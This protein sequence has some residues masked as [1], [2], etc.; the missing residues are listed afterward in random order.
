MRSRAAR[1]SLSATAW[2]ALGV[3]AYFL[4][5]TEQKISG[6]GA[7]LRTFDLHAREVTFAL[8]DARAGQQAY[9]AAGQ[10]STYWMPKVTTLVQEVANMVD[11]LRGSAV[12]G[13]AR[14]ALLEASASIAD[15]GNIDKRV[16]DY[17]GA[18]ES[19]MASDVVFSE[20]GDAAARASLQ[21]ETARIEEHQAFDADEA[22]LR[23]LQAYAIG[24]AVG[25]SA[26]ILAIFG[27]ARAPRAEMAEATGLTPDPAISVDPAISAETTSSE[28][29][30]DGD[31]M[32]L[33][34]PAASQDARPGPI[35]QIA[36]EP[37]TASSLAL[38]AAAELCTEFGRLH[39]LADLKMLL[40]RAARL[41]DASGLVVW[42]GNTSGADLQPVMA[43]GYSD[44]V[45]ELMR[46]VPRTAD[47]AAAAAYRS[48]TL[49]VVTSRP[50]QSLGAVVAPLLSAD[51][52]IGALTAEIRDGRER[53][54]DV[55]SLAS[56]FAA[57]LAGVLT[58]TAAAD[59]TVAQS[60]TAGS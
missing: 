43:H 37:A 45:L 26:L 55:Q 50:G 41:L 33:H 58:P 10:S 53:S 48:S 44:P 16:R 25:L 35:E 23:R 14:T 22:A 28:E 39:D 59:V 34:R 29:A 47:N 60:R 42:L 15:F 57:Q 3:A 46:P 9:V 2:I 40:G 31:D 30:I 56:I 49:Q 51:G 32:P 1:L 8:A 6:R 36:S 20:G 12:S 54:E 27:L 5:T 4:V 19:L 17:L 18:G 7:A 24:G 11:A 38:K 52:C 13:A 21:V